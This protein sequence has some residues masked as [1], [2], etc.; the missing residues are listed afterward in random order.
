MG[1]NL[2]KQVYLY[3][4]STNAFFNDE[5]NKLQTAI[6]DKENELK[7]GNFL[8]DDKKALVKEIK[9]LK[10]KLNRLLE[11]HGGI[12]L[13]R[14][15]ALVDTNKIS[16][17]DSTLTRTLGLEDK[18]T[19]QDII[20]V[21]AFHYSVFKS[22]IKNGFVNEYGEHYQYFTSSAGMIRNK[23]SMFIKSS[24]AESDYFKSRI[25]AGLSR[26]KINGTK[27]TN[28]D[29]QVEYGINVNKFN[30]YLALC[31]TSS[32]PVDGFNIDRAIVVDD[33]ETTLTNQKV[34]YIDKETFEVIPKDNADIPIE[35]MDGAGV[36][37]PSVSDKAIQFR[38]PHFKGL[39]IPFPYHDFIKEVANKDDV[40]VIDIY[41]DKWNII[42]DNI[43]YIFTKSQ[44]KLA[45]YYSDW[46]E[47][48]EAFKKGCE[49]VICKQEE[50]RFPDKPINYQMLQT[51]SDVTVD[52]LKEF[53][54]KTNQDIANA[55]TDKDVMLRI[56][57]IN[58]ADKDKN[59][60]Q[61]A[62]A[63]HNELLSDPYAKESIRNTR[64]SMF[65]DAKAGKLLIEGSKRTF[66]SPDLYA[67]SEWLFM[68]VENPEGLL[69]NG[70]VSCRLYRD[71]TELDVLR[72]PHL[73]REHGVRTN[74]RND[75]MS[76][77]FTTNSIYTSVHDPISKLLMFDVD[78]DEAHIVSDPTFVK[79][80]K[81]NMEGIRPLQYELAQS[82][83]E[84]VTNESIYKS[85]V[86]VYSKNIGEVSNNITKIWNL[87]QNK[88]DLNAIAQLCFINNAI[89]DYAKTLWMPNEPLEVRAKINKLTNG[90]LPHYFKY[91]KDKTDGQVL[92]IGG[93]GQ[94]EE[95]STVNKLEY[96]I[97]K[98]RIYFSR[99]V[100][101]FDYRFLMKKKKV[102]KMDQSVID[103]YIDLNG[104]KKWWIDK[105]L[106]LSGNINNLTELSTYEK[107]RASLL[108]V[109]N[110]ID[111]V[112]D[113]LI[114]Y[115]Y[116]DKPNSS[117]RTLWEAFGDILYRNLEYNLENEASK[118]EDCE[119]TFRKVNKNKVACDSCEE[120]RVRERNRERMR[121]NREKQSLHNKLA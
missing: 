23:K 113:T 115:L 111:A 41:G 72:S 81:R 4:I 21:R 61:K 5:E 64:D 106:E 58:K 24:I 33:F 110:D 52:E 49:F 6:Y 90:K 120:R 29:G 108:N 75:E 57:G 92:P 31:M 96:I 26:D 80:A 109:N 28:K 107:I 60:F 85:L 84:K 94:I 117:K 45:D 13:L 116:V 17:F 15:N 105:E 54:A 65:K 47:Y 43:Q 59:N 63:I 7:E 32:V 42:G 8:E 9:K 48:K 102:V 68:G 76:K 67:F 62:V 97:K 101:N 91:V 40:T 20:I 16:Q 118:C 70:E 44:F 34:D 53:A 88:I 55:G 87:P 95:L 93:E 50:D 22:L 66:I 51:L 56:L 78:G 36:V 18:E 1:D 25:W 46:E 11:F 69:R 112:V 103:L 10:N 83:N 2:K 12:R 30:A 100:D 3:S 37:L 19:T 71:E 39:L 86:A 14:T 79:V 119:T 27:F 74:V 73:Y 82:S 114:H 77:W 35:H 98:D 104:K 99:V 38:M 121:R 89:I